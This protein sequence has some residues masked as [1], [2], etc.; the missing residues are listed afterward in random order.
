MPN[1]LA[2]IALMAWPVVAYF[3]FR[4]M[5]RPMALIWTIV[6]GYLLLP[7]GAGINLPMVPPVDKNVVPAVSAAILCFAL[8]PRQP[9]HKPAA[10]TKSSDQFS[11][12]APAPKS[13]RQSAIRSSQTGRIT[14][15]EWMLLAALIIGPLA[16]ALQNGDPVTIGARWIQ[17]LTMY[18]GISGAISGLLAI[19]P[20]LLARRFLA[21]EKEQTLLLASICIAALL[22][23]ILAL[24]EVRMSPQLS[25]W[26]Y[27]YLYQS[28]A[29]T[30][31]G[32]GFRPAVFLQSGLWVAL[33]L[34]MGIVAAAGLARLRRQ[35]RGVW[36]AAT[37]WLLITLALCRSLGALALALAFLPIAALLPTRPQVLVAALVAAAVLVYPA[38]R[39]SNLAPVTEI[40]AIA[41]SISA[42]RAESFVYRLDNEDQLLARANERPLS[43]W[44]GWGRSRIF[45]PVSGK[46]ISVTD[47]TWIIAIGTAG[48]LG[49]VGQFGLL[50]LPVL[51]LA[52]GRHRRQVSYA[53]S[54]LCLLLAVNLIDL[55]PNATLTS[56]SWIVAG[57]L[58]GRVSASREAMPH[59]DKSALDG[60]ATTPHYRPTRR[61]TPATL[62]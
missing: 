8:T 48:W 25:K 36:L 49:Y 37:A 30:V 18:D 28:F 32:E 1:A 29:Q 14:P 53:T 2:Y 9:A 13:S 20:Y 46:D 62:R 26:I 11:S 39:G 15:L 17:G 58:M 55:I 61:R 33:F 10:A 3:L 51:A 31:R 59:E 6:G 47:G 41:E 50:A 60:Q 7:Q 56:V 23:S 42:D 12:F 44:G 22:Y 4:T 45:D 54:T 52:F 24:I 40:A 16:T 19:L 34:A 35:K 57:A 5:P 27:G 38:L 21:A 43:G